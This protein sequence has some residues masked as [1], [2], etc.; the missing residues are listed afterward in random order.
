[1]HDP[2]HGRE[3]ADATDTGPYRVA[4]AFDGSPASRAGLLA[5]DLITE[6][7]G[8]PIKGLAMMK[9]LRRCEPRP[10]RSCVW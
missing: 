6:L 9:S 2:R 3:L 1:V 10:V 8:T 4:K 7:D 5:G